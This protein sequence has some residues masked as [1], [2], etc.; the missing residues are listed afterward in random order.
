[1]ATCVVSSYSFDLPEGES[2]EFG[3]EYFVSI[4]HKFAKGQPCLTSSVTN[5][6]STYDASPFNYQR[7][8]TIN[9]LGH[10]YLKMVENVYLPQDVQKYLKMHVSRN[11]KR[12]VQSTSIPIICAMLWCAL[13]GG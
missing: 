12:E 5:Q 4:I 7:K 3:L 8:V 9:G 11:F 10:V 1:M 6:T 2:V 13:I